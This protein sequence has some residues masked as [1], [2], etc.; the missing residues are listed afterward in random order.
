MKQEWNKFK[1]GK[2]TTNIDVEN[3]IE[4]NY[5]LFEGNENFLE[6]KTAKTT[7]VWDKC[8]NLLK[9]ELKG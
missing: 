5:T 9:K 8:L 2:W 7:K 1:E 3:F 6:D 4:T